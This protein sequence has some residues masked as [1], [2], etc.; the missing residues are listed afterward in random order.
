MANSL[1]QLG[2]LHQQQGEY[3][4]ARQRYAQALEIAQELGDRRGV[5]SSLAQLGTLCEQ[6]DQ[7]PQA[8]TCLAQALVIFSDL[9]A[10]QQAQAQ[11]NLRRLRE[12]S[13]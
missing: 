3:P 1:G 2:M 10:P 6:Q 5:A 13:L 8:V 9:G 4:Q 11:R 12:K 7:L